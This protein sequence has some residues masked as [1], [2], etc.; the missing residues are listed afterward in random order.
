MRDFLTCTGRICCLRRNFLEQSP[1]LQTFLSDGVVVLGNDF[2]LDTYKNYDKQGAER[3]KNLNAFFY[4]VYDIDLSKK[5]FSKAKEHFLW[6]GSSGL[7][8]KGL[9]LLI[10]IFSK[11]RDIY[12][13]ICGASK[14]EKDFFDYYGPALS[15]SKNIINHGFVDIKSEEFKNI[16]D[17]CAFIIFPSVS[18]GGAPAV[19]NTIANGGLIP[20]LTKSTGL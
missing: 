18:E 19:L 9:D 16:M 5:D 11:R 3:F 2:V 13:H 6:F 12:L 17:Q 14:K 15:K 20:I 10:D 1:Y 7:L 8:H 4:D